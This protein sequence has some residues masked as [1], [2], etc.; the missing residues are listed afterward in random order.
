MYEPVDLG[1]LKRDRKLAK[2][3]RSASV[4]FGGV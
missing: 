2:A 3:S 1:S 4:F